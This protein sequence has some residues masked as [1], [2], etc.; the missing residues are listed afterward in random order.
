[1]K[2]LGAILASVL[3][4]GCTCTLS[5]RG[6]GQAPKAQPAED[7]AAE[8]ARIRRG[9]QAM[10]TEL[11]AAPADVEAIDA[12]LQKYGIERGAEAKE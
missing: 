8:L 1:M 3:L 11:R 12:V 7:S 2:L 4:C 9:V 10:V 5:V 6:S